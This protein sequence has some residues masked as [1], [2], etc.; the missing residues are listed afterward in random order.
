MI[1]RQILHVRNFT[2]GIPFSKLTGLSPVD[3]T[4][5]NG[6]AFVMKS[7]QLVFGWAVNPKTDATGEMV[8][9]SGLDNGKYKL[10][11]YHTWRGSFIH[12][13]ELEAKRKSVSFTVPTLKVE[14]GHAKYI[15]EDVAF[16]LEP[17]K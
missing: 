14:R 8:A 12:E 3:A 2:D 9:I 10:R 5:T 7:D 13:E 15:G 11:L 17:I 16:I 6:D 4:F 1:S